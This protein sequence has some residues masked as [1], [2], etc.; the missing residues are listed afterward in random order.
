MAAIRRLVRRPARAVADPARTEA[1]RR[2]SQAGRPATG[3]LTMHQ[4]LGNQAMQRLARSC[5]VFPSRC[6]FGGACH[7]CPARVQ[8][9]LRVS[10]PGDKCEQEADRLADAVMRTPEP[11][12]QEEAIFGQT[13]GPSLQ[14]QCSECEEEVYRQPLEEEED[15]AE[16]TLQAKEVPGRASEATPDERAD[17]EGVRSGGQPLPGSVRAFFEPRFGRD[18]SNVRVHTDAWA[19]ETARAVNARAYTVGRDVAFG[20]GQYTPGTTEGKQLLA[21]E[22]TH[23]VQQSQTALRIQRANLLWPT[24]PLAPGEEGPPAPLSSVCVPTTVSRTKRT[25]SSPIDV[26]YEKDNVNRGEI[27][28]HQREANRILHRQSIPERPKHGKVIVPHGIPVSNEDHHYELDIV[29]FN[30]KGVRYGGLGGNRPA[31]RFEVCRLFPAPS[32]DHLL[33]AKALYAEGVNAGEFPYVRDLV[34]NR[35]QWVKDTCPGDE[36]DFGGT[37]IRSI[38]EA[39]GQF[40]SVLANTPKFKQLEAELNDHSGSC[41]YTT[42]PRTGSPPRCRLVNAAIQAEA[43][44]NGNTHEYMYFR[45]DT[46]QPSTRARDQWRYPRGNYYWKISGCPSDRQKRPAK[47][48]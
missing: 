16:Q 8:A 13:R 32:G 25:S 27:T 38:L 28:L 10:Q 21:H 29:F 3:I 5:P 6:S 43:A 26:S 2:S 20:T 45:P 24:L 42:P 34:Y 9:K 37:T 23:V 18:F 36:R 15:E 48:Q 7:A 19:V 1:A 35:M 46:L 39:P 4:A 41:Q 31:V 40:A 12:T 33:F 11:H 47:G 44:G 14:R 30:R 22:L 17:I